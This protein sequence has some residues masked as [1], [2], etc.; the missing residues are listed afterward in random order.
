MS[1]LNVLYT[2][3]YIKYTIQFVK[4]F[5]LL[6]ITFLPSLA[7]VRLDKLHQTSQIC[8]TIWNPSPNLGRLSRIVLER[9]IQVI[10]GPFLRAEDPWVDVLLVCRLGD[11]AWTKPLEKAQFY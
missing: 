10:S 9:N 11:T 4:L 7:G 5:L 3:H 2:E 1:P 8:V 6:L